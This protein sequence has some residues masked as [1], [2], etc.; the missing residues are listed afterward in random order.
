MNQQDRSPDEN[1]ERFRRVTGLW[2]GSPGP[3][4]LDELLERERLE[5]CARYVQLLLSQ[6]IPKD[7][8]CA[9]AWAFGTKQDFMA[10]HG[11]SSGA[12][13]SRV[14]R[15]RSALIKLAHI[16]P[17]PPDLLE[18]DERAARD[19]RLPRPSRGEGTDPTVTRRLRMIR[20]QTAPPSADARL[21]KPRSE[22]PR[23][24]AL[25]DQEV[26]P[27][28]KKDAEQL[29][30]PLFTVLSHNRTSVQPPPPRPFTPPRVR[31]RFSDVDRYYCPFC[32]APTAPLDGGYC[33]EHIHDC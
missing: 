2:H 5:Q 23:P 29:T 32:D 18:D 11:D 20:R 12:F 31:E 7:R 27:E 8:E 6:L 26:G 9:L 15:V 21:L 22:R 25:V 13:D 10:R 24:L 17:P 14:W 30:L 16:F 4:P 3:S 19:H 33:D 1:L 28:P